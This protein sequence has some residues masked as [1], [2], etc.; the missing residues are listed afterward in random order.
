[1]KS[2]VISGKI[3]TV[4]G[5]KE[6]RK[7]RRHDEVPCVLYG[8]KET[9]HFYAPQNAFHNLFYS[10]NA[11]LIDLEI[12]GTKHNAAMQDAQ[13]HPVSDKLIHIDFKE[14]FEDK[15]VTIHIPVVISGNSVGVR[16]GGKLRQRKRNLKVRALPEDLPDHIE[17]DITDLEIGKSVNVSDL[18]YNKL[19]ILEQKH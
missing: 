4:V 2:I 16:N 17:I 3:R 7:L 13:F 5:K 15:P 11:Y 19:D 9:I 6:V 10:P 1:M 12:N 14:I 18:H 8:G